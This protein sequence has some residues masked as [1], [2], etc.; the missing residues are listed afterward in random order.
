[1]QLAASS[2]PAP[3]SLLVSIRLRLVHLAL[4]GDLTGENLCLSALIGRLVALGSED[5]KQI[6]LLVTSF[7]N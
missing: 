1:M 2:S 5:T 6:Q 7:P 4:L 3:S